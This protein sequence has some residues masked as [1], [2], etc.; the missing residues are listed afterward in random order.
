MRLYSLKPKATSKYIEILTN[1]IWYLFDANMSKVMHITMVY[2]VI[3]KLTGNNFGKN[4]EQS[5]YTAHFAI[6]W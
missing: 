3:L 2:R 4:S 5:V 6:S 1:N